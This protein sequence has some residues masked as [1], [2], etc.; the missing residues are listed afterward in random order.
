M[1]SRIKERKLV[2]QGSRIKERKPVLSGSR[3]KERKPVTYK[4]S[5]EKFE[6][7]CSD[8]SVQSPRGEVGIK[9][10][11][12]RKTISI[13]GDVYCT[14]GTMVSLSVLY[15]LYCVHSINRNMI[16]YNNK[17]YIYGTVLAKRN[18]HIV[19]LRHRVPTVLIKERVFNP[20]P[21][22]RKCHPNHGRPPATTIVVDLHACFRGMP[23]V[24]AYEVLCV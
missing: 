18:F 3:I 7:I 9:K 20:L 12:T 6:S 5:P 21:H 19:I 23:V 11:K 24:P 4:K 8:L 14:V 16:V 15:L 17:L 22:G 10:N 1:G 2:L 13:S